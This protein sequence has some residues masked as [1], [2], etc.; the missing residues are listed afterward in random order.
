MPKFSPKDIES[1]TI[2]LSNGQIVNFTG[3]E[4]QSWM[5]ERG[6]SVE[7]TA[8]AAQAIAG[9]FTMVRVREYRDDEAD[10]RDALK[11]ANQAMYDSLKNVPTVGGQLAAAFAKTCEA[12]QE[13]DRAQSLINRSEDAATLVSTVGAGA[14]VLF[15]NGSGLNGLSDEGVLLGGA[16]VWLGMRELDGDR[17]VRRKSRIPLDEVSTVPK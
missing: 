17:T 6:M 16:A 3:D 2:T 9:L 8:D 10:A 4:L 1:G 13:L 11:I 5:G 7:D 15:R 14:K 12:Q